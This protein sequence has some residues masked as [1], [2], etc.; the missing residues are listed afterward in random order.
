MVLEHAETRFVVDKRARAKVLL[1]TSTC[2]LLE[3]AARCGVTQG[4]MRDI[5]VQ[6]GLLGRPKERG[7]PIRIAETEIRTIEAVMRDSVD[8]DRAAILLGTGWKVMKDLTALRVL[9]PWV[10]GGRA[11]KH[12]YVYR[13]REVQEIL[14]RL[15]T[16]LAARLCTEADETTL[17][18]AAHAY[19]VPLAVLCREALERRLSLYGRLATGNGLQGLIVRRE[20]VLVVRRSLG[21]AGTRRLVPCRDEADRFGR[22]L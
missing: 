11:T 10:A 7:R 6:K 16:G 22:A 2:T 14:D 19:A 8:A 12:A 9:V 5:L 17:T 20:D 4:V 15:A 3:A 18:A 21:A 13:R 1:P